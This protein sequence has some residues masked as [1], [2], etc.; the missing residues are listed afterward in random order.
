MVIPISFIC[1]V[2]LKTSWA[3]ET[4]YLLNIYEV[5]NLMSITYEITQEVQIDII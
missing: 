5:Y 4:I 3:P 2:L 1:L